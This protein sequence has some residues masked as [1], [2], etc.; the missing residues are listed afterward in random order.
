MHGRTT[1]TAA[2]LFALAACGGGDAGGSASP[3]DSAG[4]TAAAPAPAD[5]APL[6]TAGGAAAATVGF[7]GIGPVRVGM[8]AEEARMALG[9]DFQ[10]AGA[11][12]GSACQYA[13]SGALPPG[14]KVMLVN[15]RVARVEVDSGAAATAEGARVGSSEAEVQRLYAGRVQV[16]PH[17]YEP[18]ARYLVVSSST[19]ADSA[20]RI[21][22]EAD[23]SGVRRYR[24]G[25]MPEVE[26]VEGCA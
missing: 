25:R 2:M 15:G 26:W 19:P 23:S 10:A 17:K 6:P 12:A 3:A 1:V 5:S 20:S 4:A 21:V 16:Q 24:A 11:E 22:F 8:P 14:V 9:G 7:A 18:G 13:R